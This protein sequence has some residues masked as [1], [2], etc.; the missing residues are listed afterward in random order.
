MQYLRSEIG[1]FGRFIEIHPPDGECPLHVPRVVVVHAVDIGP[2][3]YL[4]GTERRSYQ[5]G[6]VI[7]AAATEVIEPTVRPGTDETLRNIIHTLSSIGH[8]LPQHSAV[9]A[10]LA[11]VH[12]SRGM[13]QF[14][15]TAALFHIKGKEGRSQQFA[16]CDDGTLRHF[17]RIGRSLLRHPLHRTLHRRR[18]IGIS[19]GKQLPGTPYIFTFQTGQKQ[20]NLLFAAACRRERRY[21]LQGVRRTGHRRQ[22]RH[23]RPLAHDDV[24]HSPHIGST[25]DRGTAELQNLYHSF[26]FYPLKMIYSTKIMVFIF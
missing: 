12:E 1:E 16:L 7:A 6:T 26:P 24:G 20:C 21:S 18:R 25:A 5:G 17:A 2:Y 19:V 14:G 9:H 11:A 15:P 4:A 10:H 23:R 22:H 3:L 8:R 13:E